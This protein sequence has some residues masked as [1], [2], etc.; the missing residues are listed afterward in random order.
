MEVLPLGGFRLEELAHGFAVLR[1]WLLPVLLDRIP[2]LAQTFFISVAV[3]RNDGSDPLGM[4]QREPKPDRS[5]I[6]EDVDRV[7]IN[8]DGLCEPVGDLGQ[9]LK[10]VAER[11][12]IRG[13]R[14]AKA[15]KVG[16]HQMVAVSQGWNEIA[17]HVRRRRKA[18]Q[19]QDCRAIPGAV[20]AIEDLSAVDDGLLISGHN[21]PPVRFGSVEEREPSSS[22]RPSI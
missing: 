8:T 20:L 21:E 19:Q 15:R 12:A 14:K 7:S 4:R 11:F 22:P 3:L 16:R 18:V 2:T 5:S 13:V 9:V 17:K 6:V 1:G 10:A